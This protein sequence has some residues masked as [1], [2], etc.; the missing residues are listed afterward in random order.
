[1]SGGSE[2][3]N[4]D[5]LSGGQVAGARLPDTPCLSFGVSGVK[6][7]GAVETLP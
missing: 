1:M 3:E 7:G 4:G 5:D 6:S 2:T